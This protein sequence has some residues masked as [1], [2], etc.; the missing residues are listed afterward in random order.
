MS[1]Q[2]KYSSQQSL[3]RA[4][5][6]MQPLRELRR[7]SAAKMDSDDATR[8]DG[9]TPR[10]ADLACVIFGYVGRWQWRLSWLG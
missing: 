9:A 8:G 5:V 3:A 10:T 1:C 4:T 7:R 2:K 6:V